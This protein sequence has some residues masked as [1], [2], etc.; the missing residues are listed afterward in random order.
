M[1]MVVVQ[2]TQIIHRIIF[3]RKVRTKSHKIG[4]KLLLKRKFFVY[5]KGLIRVDFL[6]LVKLKMIV[7]MEDGFILSALIVLRC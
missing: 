4:N 3:R 1:A 2:V 7:H 6:L 5:V